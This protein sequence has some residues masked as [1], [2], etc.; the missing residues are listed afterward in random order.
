MQWWPEWTSSVV[1]CYHKYLTRICDH[2][3]KWRLPCDVVCLSFF[4]LV[5]IRKELYSFLPVCNLKSCIAASC[6]ILSISSG[7]PYPA[8]YCSGYVFV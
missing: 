3:K 2:V 1:G 5:E 6:K 7:S 4:S 8:M